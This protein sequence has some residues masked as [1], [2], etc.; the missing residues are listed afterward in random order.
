MVGNAINDGDEY[1]IARLFGELEVSSKDVIMVHGDAGVAAQLR[2]LEID[3]R[4]GFLFDELVEFVGQ[5][6]T[7]LVPAFS[8][9]FTKGVDFHIR[10]TASDVGLFS[11][12]FRRLPE[13]KRS[14]NPNFSVCSIG[15]Y[16]DQFASA[17]ATDCFGPD[18]AFDLLYKHN[19]KIVCLGCDFSRITFVHYVEQKLGVSYRYLKSFS[20]LVIDDNEQREITNTYYVRDLNFDSRG[21]LSRVKRRASDKSL[22]ASAKYG[23]FNVMS[24]SARD[25]YSTAEELLGEDQYALTQGR[26]DLN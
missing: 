3:R 10:N 1:S 6:G 4:L 11:E 23:R 5:E 24:I 16:S 22:L 7:L 13:S 8:H 9:S 2:H 15:K 18:T 17:S 20:G 26:P 25:F 21:E 19:A 12:C 14:K